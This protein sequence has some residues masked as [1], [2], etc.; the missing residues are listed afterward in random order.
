MN[1]QDNF[2]KEIAFICKGNSFKSILAQAIFNHFNTNP[3]YIA[4]SGGTTLKKELNPY[5]LQMLDERGIKYH[6]AQ[7][8][9][10]LFDPSQHYITI[11][12]M[13]CEIKCDHK[14]QNLHIPNLSG[15]GLQR[16][17]YITDIIENRI[18]KIVTDLS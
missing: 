18:K 2:V 14:Y 1:Q 12:S 8:K 6:R 7:L 13:G 15:Q 3:E 10:K 9:P 5:T 16:A 4:V 11:Y 17:R